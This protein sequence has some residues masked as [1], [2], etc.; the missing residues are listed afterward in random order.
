MQ[1]SHCMELHHAVF[2]LHGLLHLVHPALDDLSVLHAAAAYIKH[3]LN[4]L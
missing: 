3:I 1:Q 2:A 4:M